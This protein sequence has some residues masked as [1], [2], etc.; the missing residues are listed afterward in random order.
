MSV[1]DAYRS[2]ASGYYAGVREDYLEAFV[3]EKPL[4]VLEIGCGSGDLGGAALQRGVCQRYCGIELFPEAAARAREQLSQ[5]LIGDIEAMDLPWE[6]DTF[7]ALIA[8]EVLEHLR[9]PWEVLR[10]LR[11]V[12]KPGALVLASSPNVSNKRVIMMLLRG[13]WDLDDSGIMDRTHLRWFTPKSYAQMFTDCGYEV[14]SIRPVVPLGG[15]SRVLSALL[16]RKCDH[17]LWG[18]TSVRA[19]VSRGNNSVA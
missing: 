11:T 2:K 4:N 16:M 14:E 12:L 1:V 19:R 17:L 10:R 18:Q 13:R 9:D 3:E 7:D 8:S 15:K 5:V 6:P